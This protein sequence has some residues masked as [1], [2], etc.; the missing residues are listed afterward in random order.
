MGSASPPQVW[1]NFIVPSAVQGLISHFFTL[2]DTNN[3]SSGDILASQI[4]SSDGRAEFGGRWYEGT[5]G[6]EPLP[7]STW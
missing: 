4:F 7:N 1:P 2:V 6:R 3:P 5:A